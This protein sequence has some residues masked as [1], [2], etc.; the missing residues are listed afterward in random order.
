VRCLASKPR[1]FGFAFGDHISQRCRRCERWFLAATSHKYRPTRFPGRA[2]VTDSDFAAE[3]CPC[4]PAPL[5]AKLRDCLTPGL[6]DSLAMS[7]LAH[8]CA[9]TSPSETRDGANALPLHPTGTSATAHLRLPVLAC[10]GILWGTWDLQ[11]FLNRD[12][13]LAPATLSAAARKAPRLC[14]GMGYLI[15][16][17][18]RRL[19]ITRGHIAH[20]EPTVCAPHRIRARNRLT[21]G[22]ATTC[23]G[24]QRLQFFSLRHKRP[25]S[26]AKPEDLV[27]AGGDPTPPRC[28]RCEP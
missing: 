11:R 10:V 8:H 24:G 21:A 23:A 18:C 1:A 25:C 26:A 28:P 16:W 6:S 2:A 7:P 12:G 27:L 19:H 14:S 15:R 20:Q 13:V 17:R 3:A 22:T 5:P 9:A 4:R